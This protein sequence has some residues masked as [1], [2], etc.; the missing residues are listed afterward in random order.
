MRKS[1][2]FRY[3]KPAPMWA[4]SSKVGVF[5]AREEN[6]EAAADDQ[7][8]PAGNAALFRHHLES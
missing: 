1:P 3:E 2:V 4:G 8:G 7:L 6:D 5:S